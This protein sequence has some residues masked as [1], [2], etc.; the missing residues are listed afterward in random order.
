[1]PFLL[2]VHT[3]IISDIAPVYLYTTYIHSMPAVSLFGAV[4]LCV[5]I[6]T[7]TYVPSTTIHYLPVVA[8]AVVLVVAVA[9]V[10]VTLIHGTD[11]LLRIS[12][13]FS[14]SVRLFLK[15]EF[16]LSAKSGRLILIS[17]I[18]LLLHNNTSS[19][20][21]LRVPLSHG[22]STTLLSATPIRH[23]PLL[24]SIPRLPPGFQASCAG[25]LFD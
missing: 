20:C 6:A 22:R 18:P 7:N 13:S 2:Y 9:A 24:S 17:L 14:L 4:V 16:L 15:F 1:M 11:T 23:P 10:E 12:D 21:R 25:P 3:Y 8:L 5:Y 19:V